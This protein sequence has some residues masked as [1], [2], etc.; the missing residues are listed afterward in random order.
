MHTRPIA[1]I[2]TPDKI[3]TDLFSKII[4][5][6]QSV[7]YFMGIMPAPPVLAQNT[8]FSQFC[9]YNNITGNGQRNIT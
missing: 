8:H 6:I 3:M 1:R 7:A 5:C 4:I 9:N 2:F